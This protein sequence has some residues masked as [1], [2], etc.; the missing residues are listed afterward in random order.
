MKCKTCCITGGSKGIGAA[1]AEKL[2]DSGVQNLILV[3][4]DSEKFNKTLNK[5]TD[6]KSTKQ[7]IIA[8]R[9]DI[10]VHSNVIDLYKEILSTGHNVDVLV[11]NAGYASPQSIFE[12]DFD[13]F[14]RTININLYAPFLLIQK[15]L[16][17]KNRFSHI[18][19][20]ASTAGLKGRS[21][22]LTY[23]ASKAAL[24]NMSE[25]LKEELLPLGI[26]VIAVCPARCATDLRKILSPIEEDP[27][28]IMQPLDVAEVV[29]MLMSNV[30][31]FI[32][33]NHLLVRKT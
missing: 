15:L 17:N 6:K 25:S 18:I 4:R 23:S 27:T 5:L 2:L 16:Q 26:R 19:N 21:G 7:K 24:V 8:I 31:D 29:Y 30:G 28:T 1:I 13:D 12:V 10:S 33:D 22:W 11:N 32:S 9:K 3:A 14:Q 20:I